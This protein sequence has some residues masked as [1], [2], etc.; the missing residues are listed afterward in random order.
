MKEIIHIVGLNNEYKE[1]FISQ[2]KSTENSIKYSFIDID[3]ITQKITNE[4]KMSKLYDEYEKIKL[5]DDKVKIKNLSIDINTEW[6]RE[7]QSKLNKL[8]NSSENN[9][10]LIGLTTSVINNG[11]PKIHVELPT[12]YKFIV[13]IDLTDNAKQ[14][15]KNNLKEYKNQIINGTFPLEFLDLKFL[16]KRREALN[17]LYIK[18]LYILRKVEDIIKFLKEH[19]PNS[20]NLTKSKKLYYASFNE[21]TKF[22]TEKNVLLFDDEIKAILELFK[23]SQFKYEKVD[24]ESEEKIIKETIKNSLKDLEK[25]CHLYEIVDL[26]DVFFDGDNFKN[27]KKIKINKN[28]Y[29]ESVYSSLCSFGVK[30][31]GLGKAIGGGSNKTEGPITKSAK[32]NL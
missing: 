20:Q 31:I 17:Q 19:I 29:L 6:A 16:I 3:D 25:D 1:D 22:I 4:T 10:I 13:D 12:N 24:C 5:T 27:N 30:F 2:L 8:I 32:N 28:T 9:I 21:I 14:I 18:N 15:V 11:Q 7:L 23:Y 26:K